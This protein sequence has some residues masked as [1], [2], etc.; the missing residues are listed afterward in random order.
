MMRN[1]AA[2]LCEVNRPAHDIQAANSPK[3]LILLSFMAQK[4]NVPSTDELVFEHIKSRH[5]LFV[6]IEQPPEGS[7][8]TTIDVG[9][10]LGFPGQILARIDYENEIFYGLTIQNATNFKR[11]LLWQYKMANA[12]RAIALLIA[13]IRAGLRIE[14]RNPSHSTTPRLV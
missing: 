12:K 4:M 5:V 10:M 3:T 14:E 11:K 1:L 8:I 2:L 9:E 7:R 13:A 6:D